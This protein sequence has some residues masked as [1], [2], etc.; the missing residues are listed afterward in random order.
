MSCMDGRRGPVERERLEMRGYVG[1]ENK[2]PSHVSFQENNFVLDHHEQ[3]TANRNQE[4]KKI[5]W[6]RLFCA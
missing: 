5:L 2:L 3:D 4:P 1:L 6:S